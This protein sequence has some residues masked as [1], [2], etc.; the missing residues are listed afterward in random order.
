[1]PVPRFRAQFERRGET[2][3]ESAALSAASRP[4]RSADGVSLGVFRIGG[5]RPPIHQTACNAGPGRSCLAIGTAEHG[6]LFRPILAQPHRPTS[7]VQTRGPANR[8]VFDCG[9]RTQPAHPQFDCVSGR[10]GRRL[11]AKGTG[12]ASRQRANGSRRVAA[13]AARLRGKCAPMCA[14]A[15]ATYAE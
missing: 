9:P 14:F 6:R 10:S 5:R 13:P 11:I 1:M 7:A 15:S 4:T 12:T 8:P 3:L 2:I